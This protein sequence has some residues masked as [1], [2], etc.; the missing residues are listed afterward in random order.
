MVICQLFINGNYKHRCLIRSLVD[1]NR[2][3]NE[4]KIGMFRKEDAN[5]LVCMIILSLDLTLN[6]FFLMPSLSI[7][8]S[9]VSILFLFNLSLF[10]PFFAFIRPQ[11]FSFFWKN[12]FI[13]IKFS[14]INLGCMIQFFS[15]LKFPYISS[16]FPSFLNTY[17][18]LSNFNISS[19]LYLISLWI[20]VPIE[21]KYIFVQ[22][23]ARLF[24]SLIRHHEIRH[25][26]CD[27]SLR[28]VSHAFVIILHQLTFS[29]RSPR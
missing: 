27:L 24:H 13:L 7:F 18:F 20:I 4:W 8:C 15:Y 14:C 3:L 5:K 26:V 29:P 28:Y 9:F 21:C 22:V 10:L 19:Q 11:N 2:L 12:Y 1:F 25:R 23:I 17:F 16:N 6:L